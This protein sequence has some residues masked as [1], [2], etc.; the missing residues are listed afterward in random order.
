MEGSG[1]EKQSVRVTILSRPYTLLATGDPREVETVAA[2]VDE[3]M[4]SIREK[5]PTAD[6]TRIAVLACLHFADQLRLAE[7]E[8]QDLRQRKDTKSGEYAAML[9]RLIKGVEELAV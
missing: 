3:L 4:H 1:S 6:T 5:A 9:D 8:L 2:R 7:R